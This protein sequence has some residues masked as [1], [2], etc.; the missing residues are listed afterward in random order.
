[1]SLNFK[2]SSS[3]KGINYFFSNSCTHFSVKFTYHMVE[4]SRNCRVLET[5][6]VQRVWATYGLTGKH[7]VPNYKPIRYGDISRLSVTLFFDVTQ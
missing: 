3:A 6:I 7:E 5:Q 1:M 4:T 2:A